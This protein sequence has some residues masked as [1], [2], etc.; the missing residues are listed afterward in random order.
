MSNCF[1]IEN[2]GLIDVI[3]LIS[4]NQNGESVGALIINLKDQIEKGR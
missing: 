1:S 3:H 4:A 2:V